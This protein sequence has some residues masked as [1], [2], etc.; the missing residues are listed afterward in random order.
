MPNKYTILGLANR[1][2]KSMPA[3]QIYG[4]DP[5]N[6]YPLADQSNKNRYTMTP[7]KFGLHKSTDIYALDKFP[8][9][10]PRESEV[11]INQNDANTIPISMTEDVSRVFPSVDT[12]STLRKRLDAIKLREDYRG[13]DFTTGKGVYNLDPRPYYDP[14]LEDTK[15]EVDA[16]KEKIS[17]MEAQIK[18][19]LREDPVLK[20]E[21]VVNNPKIQNI[22]NQES[23]AATKYITENFYKPIGKDHWGFEIVE[24]NDDQPKSGNKRDALGDSNYGPVVEADSKEPVIVEADELASNQTNG[25]S[26]STNGTQG[27]TNSTSSTDSRNNQTNAA[28]ATNSTNNTNN[29]NQTA[30][31]PNGY[32]YA[33]PY[34]A[35]QD[36]SN[37]PPALANSDQANLS[38]S[39]SA[40]QTQSKTPE[41]KVQVSN[42]FGVTSD[43]DR[44]SKPRV[45]NLRKANGGSSLASESG[46]TVETKENDYGSEKGVSTIPRLDVR[47]QMK[48]EN[49][50]NSRKEDSKDSEKSATSV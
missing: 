35:S 30:N 1:N 9:Y 29:W 2:N 14:T 13:K 3:P 43:P 28:N 46:Q 41:T 37:A 19:G 18:N 40:I 45:F 21:N 39:P 26:N 32:F 5:D 36:S 44:K 27:N 31:L 11:I 16:L 8:Y 4:K 17:S 25:D 42:E 15:S 24:D 50:G 47:K 34:N 38:S 6:Y 48:Q 20:F 23:E 10:S 22:Y 7:S 49:E 12:I 33:K